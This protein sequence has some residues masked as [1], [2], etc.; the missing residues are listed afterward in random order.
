MADGQAQ[1]GAA[2]AA[3]GLAVGLRKGAKQLRNL[4]GIHANASVA[5]TDAQDMVL[6][7]MHG[8]QRGAL[9]FNGHHHF[10]LV[11]ELD[12][13]AHQI[14]QHLTEPQRVAAQVARHIRSD[15][16]HDFDTFFLGAQ[17]GD[18]GDRFQN[19]IQRKLHGL[20]C[21]HAGFDLGIVQD[22]VDD[23]QQR[24]GRQLHF[25]Q[26]VALLGRKRCL[27][28]QPGHADH[29]V[30]RRANLMAH[31][32]Q[33]VRFGA[34]GGLGGFLGLL[35]RY[36][37][38]ALAGDVQQNAV[39]DHA[40]FQS[41]G[42]RAAAQPAH[43]ALGCDD[44]KTVVKQPQQPERLVHQLVVFINIVGVHRTQIV[45]AVRHDGR[46]GYAN[47]ALHPGA[48]IAQAHAVVIAFQAKDRAAGQVVG[49]CFQA[50][51][52]ILAF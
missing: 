24:I 33:K 11:R 13:I 30:H 39:P 36:F 10:T 40:A 38:L 18:G 1:T 32:G 42:G 49:Q 26:I 50:L 4:R 14:V 41:S 6:R 46:G 52:G 45:A 16:V 44:A 43:H 9:Q 27:A 17:R 48:D 22:V 3:R 29:R 23:G 35:Q 7:C 19:V 28:H 21:Q 31:G 20:Q 51:L 47:Q 37:G 2:I 5:H 34:L 25:F 12:G 8:H 15:R